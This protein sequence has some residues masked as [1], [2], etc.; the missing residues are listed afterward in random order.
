MAPQPI[1]IA[2]KELTKHYLLG[3]CVFVKLDGTRLFLTCY[4]QNVYNNSTRGQKQIIESSLR[5]HK[6]L[7]VFD[8]EREDNTYYAH[9]IVILHGVVVAHRL[10]KII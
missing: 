7:V 2:I 4:E 5:D 9:D 6:L 3:G 10:L 1:D 8:I